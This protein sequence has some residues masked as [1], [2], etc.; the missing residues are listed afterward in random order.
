MKKTI[1]LWS[2]TCIMLVA[3]VGCGGQNQEPTAQFNAQPSEAQAGVPV[4]FDGTRS[5]DGDGSIAKY[6]WDFGDGTKAE[7]ATVSHT[8][9]DAKSYTVKLTVTDDKN[10]TAEATQTV[11]VNAVETT[12]NNAEDNTTADNNTSDNNTDT[13]VAD[14]NTDTFD[15]A[16]QLAEHIELSRGSEIRIPAGSEPRYLMPNATEGTWESQISGLIFNALLQTND[17]FE[18]IPGLAHSWEWDRDNL[19]YTFHLREGVKFHDYAETGE[20]FDCSDVLFSYKAWMHP[21]YP[22][23][24]FGNFDKVVGAQEFHDGE[25]TDWPV[26]G[27]ECVDDHTFKVTLTQVERTFLP[28]AVASS[29][30]MPQHVYEPFFDENGYDKIQGVDSELGTTI[31]T[32]PYMLDEW[33]AAQF[34]SLNRFDEYWMAPFGRQIEV[35]GQTAFPGIEKIYWV[36]MP[37]TDAQYAALLSGEVDVLDTRSNVDQYF[38]L[39][40]N[41][42]FATFVYPQLT[43]DYWHWNLRNELFQEVD[44]RKAMCHAIDRELMVDRVLRGLGDLTN[45]PSHPLRWD[46]D[47]SLADIHPNFDPERVVE[48][49]E[50]AGWTIEKDGDGNIASGAVW[51]KVA[52]D[53]STMKMEFEIAHNTPNARRQD[54]AIIMQQQLSE[55]GFKAEVR[56][57]ET[58][59]F[60]NDYLDGSFDFQTAIAGWRM[61]TDPD[62]TSIWHT[63]SIGTSFNWHAYSNPEID[64]LIE[65]GLLYAD[66]DKARPIYQE[67]NR[68]LVETQGYC[69]LAFPSAT[70]AAK[71]NMMGTEAWS[72]LNPYSHLDAWYWEGMGIPV[73]VMNE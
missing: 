53:G 54:F 70:F 52:E 64:A 19:T 24:R 23:V 9:A 61:G 55:M 51:E 65:E 57:M 12:D 60:Y 47:E 30:I 8:Y 73:T 48:L 56:G 44:V 5:V 58:N 31:G 42:N 38:Q 40:E 22:G 41:D 69:W 36:I 68:K 21:D 50:G 45:G 34:V 20:M 17:N 26:E 63:D 39:S 67:I 28:F 18:Q 35:E 37:D 1:F 14:N 4:A 7:G 32:G 13:N 59:A 43:Y 6:E 33:E 15:A 49:M 27:L 10:A 11:V 2:L 25:S 66:L 3:L 62:G 46:W 71:P 72:A 29:G 16:A